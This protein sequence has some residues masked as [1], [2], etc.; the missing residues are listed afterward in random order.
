[1][2]PQFCPTLAWIRDQLDWIET[3]LMVTQDNPTS[4]QALEARRRE[5][6]D[7]ARRLCSPNP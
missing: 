7:L 3:G 2:D 1:M 6:I 5:L 4:S